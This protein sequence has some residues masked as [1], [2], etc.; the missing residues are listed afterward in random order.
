MGIS[1]KTDI[2]FDVSRIHSWQLG[3]GLGWLVLGRLGSGGFGK[4][5]LCDQGLDDFI[6]FLGLDSARASGI[7]SDLPVKV[8][9]N[10]GR[11]PASI[12]SFDHADHRAFCA[13]GRQIDQDRHG[14]LEALHAGVGGDDS[15]FCGFGLCDVL[16]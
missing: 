3:S 4:A 1:Q 16:R 13:L 11:R 6:G 14:E 8:H 2:R 5:A 7:K 10:G 12:R 15:F 9:D